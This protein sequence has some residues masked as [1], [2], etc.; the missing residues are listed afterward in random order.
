MLGMEPDDPRTSGWTRQRRERVPVRTIAAV[1]AMVLATAILVFLVIRLE[2]VLIWILVAMFFAAVLSP[3]TALAQRRLHLNRGF[4]TFVVFL[5]TVLVIAGIVTV[6]VR[7]AATQGAEL[8][9]S[10]PTIVQQAAAGHGPV[11]DLLTR[12][13]VQK[14]V[15][16]Y[17]ADHPD[18]TTSTKQLA[19]FAPAVIRGV[20]NGLAAVVT[21]F[22]LAYLMVLEGPIFVNAWLDALPDDRRERVRRVAT[23]CGKAV[24]GYVTGNLLISVIAG[25]ITWVALLALGVPYA[26]VMAVFVGLT[27]LIPLVGATIGAVLVTLIAF[28]H[29]TTDGI[30]MAVIFLVYQQA[31]NHLLQ[32]VIM[33]RTVKLNPLTVLVSVLL[34]VELAGILGALLAIPLAGVIAVVFRDLYDTRR[35]RLK[36]EP[37]IG[38]DEVP[39]DE[40]GA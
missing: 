27:D 2:R 12:L 5:V 38:A 8:V 15:T 20:A 23:D 19:Q 3:V 37:T 1:I 39:A 34:G 36:P 40:V 33:S 25:S 29:G 14:Y 22:V 32:P 31:E 9:K 10:A 21:I 30:V 28:L 11:G 24:T 26:G 35:R 13:H 4:A 7:P 18:L 16:R 6:L 17:V